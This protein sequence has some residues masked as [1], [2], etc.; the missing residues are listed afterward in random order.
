MKTSWIIASIASLIFLSPAAR[1][2][3]ALDEYTAV[4]TEDVTVEQDGNTVVLGGS[5][6]SQ[7]ALNRVNNLVQGMDNIGRVENNILVQ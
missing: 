7:A 5:I 6:K 1:V 4:N 2:Q 3:T